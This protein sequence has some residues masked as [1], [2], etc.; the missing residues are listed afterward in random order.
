MPAGAGEVP[1]V[2]GA[3]Q[4]PYQALDDAEAADPFHDLGQHL[5]EE[6]ELLP[7]E[8][9]DLQ[10]EAVDIPSPAAAE[11]RPA[12]DLPASWWQRQGQLAPKEAIQ[13]GGARLH[14]THHIATLGND[15][16]SI[17]FCSLCGGTT[18]GSHS[19]LLAAPCR[20]EARGT[21]QR[22]INRMLLKQMWPTNEMEVLFGRAELRP[23]L[24]F[25][26]YDPDLVRIT[27]GQ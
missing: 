3:E 23:P 25:V 16:A 24:V 20:R 2:A 21:S 6:E 15:R 8:E 26:D 14:F 9:Q 22:H 12:E 7:P 10:A 4:A 5:A 11:D 18:Q 13:V 19:P 27:Y 1:A 17:V